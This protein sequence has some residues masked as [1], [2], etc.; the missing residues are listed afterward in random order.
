MLNG[1][2]R[3]I[4]PAELAALDYGPYPENYEEILEDYFDYNSNVLGFRIIKGKPVQRLH[5]H[6]IYFDTPIYGWSGKVRVITAREVW[7]KR[8]RE[9]IYTGK[10]TTLRTYYIRYGEVVGLE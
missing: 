7:D 5:S 9:Y 1:C 4:T 3:Q 6:E 10:E 2:G 8:R